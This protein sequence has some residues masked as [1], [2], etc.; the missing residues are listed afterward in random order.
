MFWVDLFID[1]FL[2]NLLLFLFAFRENLHRLMLLEWLCVFSY[3]I[4]IWCVLLW[5]LELTTGILLLLSV[6]LAL[7]QVKH[8]S[9]LH[10]IHYLSYI[11]QTLH[12]VLLFLFCL[13]AA[14]ESEHQRD[15]EAVLAGPCRRRWRSGSTRQ[16]GQ[17][18]GVSRR[19]RLPALA[20]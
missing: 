13:P 11:F 14:V 1:H 8:P 18:Q 19:T 10:F 15:G 6:H 4:C 20:L 5:G 16:A 12:S 7:N 3:L 17:R 2:F 9:T